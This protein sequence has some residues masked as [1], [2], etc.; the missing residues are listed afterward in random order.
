VAVYVVME[1]PTRA[2]ALLVRDGFHLFGFLTPPIWLL[3]HRLWVEAIVAFAAAMVLGVLGEV[4]GLGLAGS[5]LSLLVSIYVGI[6]GAALRL[7]ALRRRGWR[8]WGV[9]EADSF[10]DAEARY[11]FDAERHE[12]GEQNEPNPPAPRQQSV[13][14]HRSGPALGLFNYPG[15]A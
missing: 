13:P 12:S 3:W 4:L 2:D 9:V 15:K 10:D 14:V 5:L 11:L 1:P 6:E 7:A 8:E